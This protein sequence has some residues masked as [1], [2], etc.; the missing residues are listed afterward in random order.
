MT[1]PDPRKSPPALR[2]L[3]PEQHA[4]CRCSATEPPFSGAY[5]KH[6]AAGRY[7]CVAC[8]SELFSSDSKYDSGSGWPSFWAPTRPDALSEHPDAS[9]GMRRVE[10]RCAHCAA[11]L[12]HVFPDGPPPTGL[13][14]CI[15]SL[16]L[17]FVAA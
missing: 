3:T 1:T 2:P 8:G 17:E 5:W 4:V 16:A 6:T 13:R 11:H 14:Y 15:N 10:V 9:H 7:H 12:G